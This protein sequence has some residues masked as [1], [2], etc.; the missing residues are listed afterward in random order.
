MVWYTTIDRR[1]FAM[2]IGRGLS[3]LR[4]NKEPLERWS[5]IALNVSVAQQGDD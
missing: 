1:S 4:T 5:L 2:E 3:L